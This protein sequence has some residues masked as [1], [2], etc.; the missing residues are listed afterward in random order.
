M[1]IGV[2]KGVVEQLNS[3]AMMVMVKVLVREEWWKEGQRMELFIVIEG[4][5]ACF[6]FCSGTQKS[7]SAEYPFHQIRNIWANGVPQWHRI[8]LI[9][10][11]SSPL[12]RSGGGA[13]KFRLCMLFS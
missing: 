3:M 11:S 8:F 7:S 12:I 9:L 1:G 6:K 5:L 2:G 10:Y 13:G 4:G